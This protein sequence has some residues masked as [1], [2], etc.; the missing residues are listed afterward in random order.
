MKFQLTKSDNQGN[1]TGL[2]RVGNERYHAGDVIETDQPLDKLFRNKF[3]RVPDTT[4]ASEP[5][6]VR[7]VRT[8]KI[9]QPKTPVQRGRD[10]EVGNTVTNTDT[11]ATP[12]STISPSSKEK[13]NDS[14]GEDVTTKYPNASLLHLK[15]YHSAETGMY[16]IVDEDEG[17]FV[18][19]TSKSAKNIGRFLD[20]QLG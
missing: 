8:P 17:D 15:V 13:I 5:E 3:V 7:A 10:E 16:I 18:V 2:H 14:R 1:K 4:P 9:P 6:I 20:K 11:N 12:S 19:K